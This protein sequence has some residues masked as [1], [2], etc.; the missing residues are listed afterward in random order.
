V[1]SQDIGVFNIFEQAQQLF[2]FLVDKAEKCVNRDRGR[3]GG[4][5]KKPRGFQ[6]EEEIKGNQ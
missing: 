6:K 2:D 5:E 1:A 3:A 4:R